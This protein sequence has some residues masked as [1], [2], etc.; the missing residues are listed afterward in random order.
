MLRARA[1]AYHRFFGSFELARQSVPPEYH[2][3]VKEWI[4]QQDISPKHL[5]DT[6]LEPLIQEELSKLEVEATEKLAE[7]HFLSAITSSNDIAEAY[8]AVARLV[9]RLA[10]GEKLSKEQTEL[11]HT[12]APTLAEAN[13]SLVGSAAYLRDQQ[14]VIQQVRAA[15]REPLL[16]STASEV[17][18]VAEFD[19][20]GDEK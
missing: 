19:P 6:E 13:K 3:E 10:E 2:K 16:A 5:V 20:E 9:K 14:T 4:R 11:A 1:I 7:R 18:Q 12:I 17:V 15:A 8:A